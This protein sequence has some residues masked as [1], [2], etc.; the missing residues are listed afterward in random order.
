MYMLKGETVIRIDDQ[1]EWFSSERMQVARVQA[2]WKFKKISIFTSKRVL[3][4]FIVRSELTNVF[5]SHASILYCRFLFLSCSWLLHHP[6]RNSL[7]NQ[8]IERWKLDIVWKITI[9]WILSKMYLVYSQLSVFFDNGKHPSA[10]IYIRSTPFAGNS[11]NP[12]TERECRGELK[13]WF[14]L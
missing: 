11:L 4:R 7:R 5:P 6:Y 10:E 12:A 13:T 9:L 14:F 2:K 8:I 1:K 3:L